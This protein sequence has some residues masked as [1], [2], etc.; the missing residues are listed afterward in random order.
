MC[1]R[2]CQPGRT[3]CASRKGDRFFSFVRFG[4]SDGGAGVAAESAASA[5]FEYAVRPGHAW[6]LGVGWSDP[7]ADGLRD[8]Y[9]IETAYK[10]QLLKKF[11]LTPNVQY[12]L[13]PANQPGEDSVWV[14]GLKGILTL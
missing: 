2:T 8:E 9:V 14:L 6:N 10:F 7:V 3:T 12:I 13:D 4:H 5:G 11:S 1:H